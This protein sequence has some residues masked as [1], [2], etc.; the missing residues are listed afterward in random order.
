MY[1]Q[2]CSDLIEKL[3]PFPSEEPGG[4]EITF[5]R[6]LLNICQEAYEGSNKLGEEVKQM[7]AP[8]QESERRDKERMVKLRTLGNS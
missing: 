2:L 5:K 3:P 6:V 8:E 1:A 7:T 4:K